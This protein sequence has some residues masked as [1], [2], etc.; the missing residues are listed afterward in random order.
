MYVFETENMEPG[1]EYAIQFLPL[2]RGE[3]LVTTFQI[4]QRPRQ[5]V[6]I[7]YEFHLDRWLKSHA[8]WAIWHRHWGGEHIFVL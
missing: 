2:F 6:E 5:E 8:E 4:F 3:L 1:G 7:H